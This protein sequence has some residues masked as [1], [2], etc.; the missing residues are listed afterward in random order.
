MIILYISI[1]A[2]GFLAIIILLLKSKKSQELQPSD[3][4]KNINIDDEENSES[5]SSFLKRLRKQNPKKTTETP[6]PISAKEAA[7]SLKIQTEKKTQDSEDAPQ[8]SLKSEKP[9]QDALSRIQKL[10]GDLDISKKELLKYQKIITD[11][12]NELNKKNDELAILQKIKKEENVQQSAYT[13]GYDQK[14]IDETN[15][16]YNL[17]KKGDSQASLDLSKQEQVTPFNPSK[18]KEPTQDI[19]EI[20]K[21]DD[22]KSFQNTTLAPSEDNSAN[23]NILEKKFNNESLDSNQEASEDEQFPPDTNIEKK[24]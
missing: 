23:K 17:L 2:I 20:T 10:E 24:D 3:L 11:L 18:P 5:D 8:N 16:S 4:L 19:N 22:A 9:L 15:T 14:L 21:I 12:Q 1:L 7:E 13:Q 6:E